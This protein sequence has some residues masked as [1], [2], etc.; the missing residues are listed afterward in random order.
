[1]RQRSLFGKAEE[2][3]HLGHWH[4]SSGQVAARGMAADIIEKRCEACRFGG[5]SPLESAW[6]HRQ[7]S[8]HG[9][10]VGWRGAQCLLDRCSN[11]RSDCTWIVLGELF[12]QESF[13]Q[14]RLLS[15]VPYVQPENCDAAPPADE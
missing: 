9:D 14:L 12:S 11:A 7:H 5:K 8:G 4:V 15:K 6:M 2:A 13:G 10:N 1:M 3:G